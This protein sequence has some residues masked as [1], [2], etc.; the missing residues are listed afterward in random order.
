MSHNTP[1]TNIKVIATP[2]TG[3]RFERIGDTFDIVIPLKRDGFAINTLTLSY[4]RRRNYNAFSVK[5]VI[6]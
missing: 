6:I 1:L 2:T 4:D 5:G 3:R